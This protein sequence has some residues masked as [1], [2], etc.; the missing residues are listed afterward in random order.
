[1]STHRSLIAE[2]EEVLRFGAH[3]KRA[4]TLGQMTE[5]FLTGIEFF[6][7]EQVEL[8]DEIL[9]RLIEDIETTVLVELSNNLAPIDRAPPHVIKR[10]AQHEEIAVAA[11]VLSCS[12]R[13]EPADLVEIAAAAGQEHLLA[14]SIRKRLEAAVTSVLVERGNPDVLLSVARNP[15]AAF[16][17]AGFNTL[18]ARAEGNDVLTESVGL[19]PDIPPLLLERLLLR[20]TRIVRESLLGSARGDAHPD[21]SRVLAKVARDIG[22]ADKLRQ[23]DAAEQLIA[24][25]TKAGTLNQEAIL[26]F[27]KAGQAEE[28]VVGLARLCSVSIDVVDRLMDFER[29]EAMLVPCRSAGL[30]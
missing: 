21:I 6:T 20:A 29:P 22:V 12:N 4:Q 30:E 3:E 27:A 13:L 11:P 7:D 16:S 8:F 1:M 14:I 23:Y 19:R 24:A 17:E 9:L 18:V 10:L 5:F 2:L 15:G 26:E 28:F 25:K